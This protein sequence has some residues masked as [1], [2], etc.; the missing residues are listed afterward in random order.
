[1]TAEDLPA[2]LKEEFELVVDAMFG[3][4]FHGE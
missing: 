1:M 4:S 2:K 3:F